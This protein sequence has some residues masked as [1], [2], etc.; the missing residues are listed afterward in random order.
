MCIVSRPTTRR[1]GDA[2]LLQRTH[3]ACVN[4]TYF[5]KA[6]SHYELVAP[7]LDRR[8]ANRRS[9][10][11]VRADATY[12]IEAFTTNQFNR[13]NRQRFDQVPIFSRTYLLNL[14]RKYRD[15]W[16]GDSKFMRIVTERF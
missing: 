7:I 16:G 8:T 2:T 3:E 12:E 10:V 4:F 1:R 6:S 13:L 11:L 15:E 14:W 9:P 5:I